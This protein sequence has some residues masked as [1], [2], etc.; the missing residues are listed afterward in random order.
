MKKVKRFVTVLLNI[1]S[2]KFLEVLFLVTMLTGLIGCSTSGSFQ[3]ES[4]SQ[5]PTFSEAERPDPDPRVGL[6]PGVFDAEEAIWN[7]RKLSSTT[8]A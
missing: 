8:S 1:L 2:S 5:V 3:D 6:E 7:L 4:Q